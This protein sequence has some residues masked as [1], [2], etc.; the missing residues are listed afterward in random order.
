MRICKR[1]FR[2]I[3]DNFAGFEVQIKH[4]YSP[5]WIE[6]NGLNTEGSIESAKELIEKT[7]K[8]LDFKSEVVHVCNCG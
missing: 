7:K 2:I 3:T 5:F 4:W 6:L 1:R 8:D